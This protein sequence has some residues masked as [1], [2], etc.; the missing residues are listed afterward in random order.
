MV[1]SGPVEISPVAIVMILILGALFYLA[2]LAIGAAIAI[3]VYRR[4]TP[5]AERSRSGTWRAAILGA[6]VATA[7][8]FGAGILYSTFTTY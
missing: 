7:L 8:M 1:L 2:P 3:A 4:R 6:V 5:E